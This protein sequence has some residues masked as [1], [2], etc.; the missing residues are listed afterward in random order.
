MSALVTNQ[1]LNPDDCYLLFSLPPT[2][3]AGKKF[4][5]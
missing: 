2:M 3:W 4:K 1:M 5:C